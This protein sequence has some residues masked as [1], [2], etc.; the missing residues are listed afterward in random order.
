MALK[1]EERRT[2]ILTCAYRLFGEK[3]YD[4]VS[5]GD[6]AKS[7]GISKSLLQHYYSQKI[8]IV[9]TMVS[10]LLETS[11]SYMDRLEKREEEIFQNISDFDMLFFKGVAG[12]YKLRQ[13]IISSV[14]QEECLDVWIETICSWLRQ[15]CGET[16]FTY[17]QLKTAMCFSM[18]GSMHLFQHQDE[19]DI[20]YRRF[21]RIHIRAILT[22]LNYEEERI[23]EIIGKTDSRIERFD[24]EDYLKFCEEN[25][26]WLSL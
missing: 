22:F 25:I 12:D 26:G 8:E 5:L 7:V 17:R 14:R 21:C 9:K 16:T 15:Y 24:V 1:N 11:F 3:Q 19:L 10:E 20:S 4:H 18:A 23:A 13:F 2:E 6:I